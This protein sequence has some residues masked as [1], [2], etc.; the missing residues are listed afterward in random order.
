MK[1]TIKKGCSNYILVFLLL[2]GV[3]LGGISIT[4]L[5]LTRETALRAVPVNYGSFAAAET[6]PA[7]AEQM[8]EEIAIGYGEC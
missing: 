7:P 2:A 5:L 3:A 4:G 1:H 8:Q 6:A